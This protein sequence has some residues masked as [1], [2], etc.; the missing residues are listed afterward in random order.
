MDG[1]DALVGYNVLLY[2]PYFFTRIHLPFN[3]RDEA[4]SSQSS[5]PGV[6]MQEPVVATSAEPVSNT[7]GV[8]IVEVNGGEKNLPTA[9]AVPVAG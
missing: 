8:N 4:Q 9:V 6:S 3:L 1:Y 5:Q 2:M 7:Y